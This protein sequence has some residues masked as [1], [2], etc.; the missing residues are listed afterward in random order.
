MTSIDDLRQR[1]EDQYL[2]PVLEETPSSPLAVDID[3]TQTTFRIVPDVL[4][5]DDESYIAPGRILELDY[6]LVRVL[7]YDASTKEVSCRRGVRGSLAAS[8]TAATTDVRFPTRWPRR[9][10][11]T[12]IE[13]G[14]RSL[15]QPL[16]LKAE[17]QA[18]VSSAQ[19]VQLPLSTI[20]IIKVEFRNDHSGRWDEVAYKLHNTH[21]HDPSYAS[22][23]IGDVPYRTQCTITYG[24][25]VDV[26]AVVTDDIEGMPPEWERIIL[27]DAAAE[28]LSGVDIDATTQEYLTQQ[29]RL[30]NFPVKSG[31]SISQNLI[32]YK[33]Y[34]VD[35]AEKDLKAA[36]PRAV[37]HRRVSLYS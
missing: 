32:R 36:E 18:T 13:N 29:M 16:F 37:A 14:I 26:P 34:L 3:N 28:M 30:E 20:R 17:V 31:S 10:M 15:W 7:S 5:P 9:I 33:E 35:E 24:K 22:I 8:H 1:L 4:S 2:E 21:P 23:E 12:S 27:A 6:E 11:K 25:K 19:Y